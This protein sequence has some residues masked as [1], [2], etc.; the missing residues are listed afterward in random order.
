[1]VIVA[2]ILANLEN[3][4][5]AEGPTPDLVDQAA[6]PPPEPRL[7]PNPIDQI[8]PAEELEILRA[9]E[10]VILNAYDWVDREAGIVRI[11]IEEAMKLVV[12]ENQ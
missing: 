8:T 4:R 12:E 7:Q 9:Q 11:P 2:G 1:M 10:E 5:A 3:R 6:L